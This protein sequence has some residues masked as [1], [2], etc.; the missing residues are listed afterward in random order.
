[1]DYVDQ[2]LAH[3]GDSVGHKAQR[4]VELIVEDEEERHDIGTQIQPP[5]G[6]V[7]KTMGGEPRHVP[8]GVPAHGPLTTNQPLPADPVKVAAAGALHVCADPKRE[9]QIEFDVL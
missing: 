6:G 1:M 7:G 3:P 5:P 9:G 2:A 8:R 4:A